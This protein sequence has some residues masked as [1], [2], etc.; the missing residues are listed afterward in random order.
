ME[1]LMQS[2][3]HAFKTLQKTSPT[4]K[5]KLLNDIADGIDQNKDLILKTASQETNLPEPRL[6]VERGR[7]C[8]QL[9]TMAKEIEQGTWQEIVVDQAIPDRQPMPKPEIRKMHIGIGPIVVFGASNFPLA[10]STIGGDSVSALAAGCPVIYKVHPS[11]PVTSNIINNIIQEAVKVNGL[12]EGTFIHYETNDFDEV[13][14]LVQHPIVKGV[15]FTGSFKGGMAIYDYAKERK[16]P[17]PVFC[18]MGSVNPV[19]LLPNALKSKAEVWATNYSGSITN[20]VGQFCT[21]PGLILGIKGEE[22][23]IFTNH[24]TEAINKV[25]AAPMLSESIYNNYERRKGEVLAQS[26]V[27][28]IS[29]NETTGVISGQPTIATVSG[30]EFMSN[31][32]LHEEVFGPFSLIVECEDSEE[33]KATL[34]VVEGQLTASIIC[35]PED[36]ALASEIRDIAMYKA[37][38]VVF[39]GIPTGVEVT[40]AMV[41][42]GPFPSSTDSRYTAVGTEAIRRWTR[43]VSIQNCPIDLLPLALKN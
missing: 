20:S 33:L 32:L 22:L 42:G 11:H 31:H 12:P 7:T 18:E 14:K 28:K 1:H 2:A 13:K 30:K 24:L 4:I 43:P 10:Y 40:T 8:F 9:R 5:A 35:E 39:N 16:E 34:D 6:E 17:I 36:N 21:N 41:H 29:A 27:Q 26:N 15:G 23:N 25:N 38:R 37:G 19:I 3:L